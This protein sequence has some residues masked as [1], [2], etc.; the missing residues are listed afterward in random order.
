VTGTS[1]R[2]SASRLKPAMFSDATAV[3]KAS[4][5]R[6]AA[7]PPAQPIEAIAAAL[8]GPPASGDAETLPS[9]DVVSAAFSSIALG[10]A[11][12][13]E[14]DGIASTRDDAKGSRA[15]I[16][17]GSGD[18][19]SASHRFALST[20]CLDFAGLDI[21]QTHSSSHSTGNIGGFTARER[22]C[23]LAN[24]TNV[25]PRGGV[26]DAPL[27]EVSQR[28]RLGAAAS[29]AA[30]SQRLRPAAAAGVQAQQQRRQRGS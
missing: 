29:S 10:G 15:S 13:D 21:A 30:I 6:S 8:G 14:H 20:S 24:G 16:D 7:Q 27:E 22:V 28:L 26:T 23:I 19:A 5:A 4:G 11:S 17:G 1:L 3:C 12:D 25:T 2:G 18:R 9:E